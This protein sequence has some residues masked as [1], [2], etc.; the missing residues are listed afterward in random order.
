MTFEEFFKKKKIDLDALEK[1]EPVLFAEFKN[2]YEQMG[3]K[4]FD[5]TKKYW[6]NRLRHQYHLAPEPKAEK[7]I[8]SV[9]NPLQTQAVAEKVPAGTGFVP[10]LTTAG[11]TEPAA[12]EPAGG[13]AGSAGVSDFAQ[14]LGFTPKFKTAKTLPPTE[15]TSEKEPSETTAAESSESQAEPAAAPPT[16][17]LGFKPKFKAANPS[18]AV[19]DNASKELSEAAD[20]ELSESKLESQ[21]APPAPKLGFKPKFK[22]AN[23]SLAVENSTSKEASETDQTVSSDNLAEAPAAAPAAK[24]GFKPKFKAPDPTKPAEPAPAAEKDQTQ[25]QNKAEDEPPAKQTYK[26]RFNM[27]N[28]PPKKE[29]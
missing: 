5:H 3:E 12:S 24:L 7:P 13:N 29:E 6:F 10:E 28:M 1:A 4:S 19:E 11:N 9:S 20:N 14:Q 16:P 22:A 2:H 21:A 25:E 26:P 27:K 15:K 23:P 18:P 17:K 8:I